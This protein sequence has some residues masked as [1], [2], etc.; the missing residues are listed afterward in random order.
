M[1]R[2]ATRYEPN[3]H[4]IF[5]RHIKVPDVTPAHMFY[6]AAWKF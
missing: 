2:A 3:Q 5:S 4:P 6:L 1:N